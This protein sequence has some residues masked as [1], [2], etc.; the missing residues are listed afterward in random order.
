MQFAYISGLAVSGK[1]QLK[2]NYVRFEVFMTVTM[3]NS[4]FWYVMLLWLL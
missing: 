1:E 2:V 3:K 4:I